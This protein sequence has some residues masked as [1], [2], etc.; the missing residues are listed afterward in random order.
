MTVIA[1]V[2]VWAFARQQSGLSEQQLA[3]ATL[4]NV[5]YLNERFVVAQVSYTSNSITLYIYNNGQIQEQVAQ[6][7]VYNSTRTKIDL[8]YSATRVTDLNHAGTCS[9][10]PTTALENPTLL[11]T[12]PT[13]Y[14]INAGAVSSITLTFPTCY[15]GTF[16]AGFTY[17]VKLLG[18]Y[19]NT[20]T[21]FQWM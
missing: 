2:G 14:A 16:K 15:T 5:N 6:I 21:Y 19:G 4:G 3:S 9:V 8:T 12:S 10:T 18:R 13:S 20:V 11:G 17:Y 7:E 1:G